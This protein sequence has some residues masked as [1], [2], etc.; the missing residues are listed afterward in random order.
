MVTSRTSTSRRLQDV[1]L[2]ELADSPSTPL[3]TAELRRRADD[4]MDTGPSVPV[5]IE[6]VYRALR[7]L[8]RRGQVVHHRP[9]GRHAEWSLTPSGRA[10]SPG[11]L[12]AGE[13]KDRR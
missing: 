9:D 10:A 2:S 1:L 12:D 11:R 4:K 7:T 3:S 6:A 5:A 13:V 8:H